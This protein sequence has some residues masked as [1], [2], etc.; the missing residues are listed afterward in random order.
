MAVEYYGQNAIR[1]W[2]Q[3]KCKL[4]QWRPHVSKLLILVLL[5]R[6]VLI[7]SNS[8]FWFMALDAGPKCKQLWTTHRSA[9]KGFSSFLLHASFSNCKCSAFPPIDL[10]VLFINTWNNGGRRSRSESVTRSCYI[11]SVRRGWT[12]Q[13]C[14]TSRTG[15]LSESI[16]QP[17]DCSFPAVKTRTCCYPTL[18][19]CSV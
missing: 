11:L 7:I 17:R 5:V 19:C 4:Q 15:N 12:K 14:S 3:Q 6:D 2:C 1:Y 18:K 10:Q 9:W 8:S 16:Q 13:L